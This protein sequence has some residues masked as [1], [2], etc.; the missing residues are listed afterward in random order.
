VIVCGGAR[1]EAK[2]DSKEGLRKISELVRFLNYTN[3]IVTCVPH[4]FDPQVDSCVNRD[5]ELFNRKLQKQMLN[6][7]RSVIKVTTKNILVPMVF[8]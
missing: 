5:I 4:C 8:T 2:N 7:Q 3:V 1:D 6:V